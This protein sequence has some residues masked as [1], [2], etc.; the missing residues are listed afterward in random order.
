MIK[1]Y[2]STFTKPSD[3]YP[4]MRRFRDHLD[5]EKRSFADKTWDDWASRQR[6][7]PSLILLKQVLD[8]SSLEEAY[9]ILDEDAEQASLRHRNR[10]R[11]KAPKVPINSTAVSRD[12]NSEIPSSW[13]LGGREN[14][15]PHVLH[16]CEVREAAG[17][18]TT[19]KCLCGI[20]HRP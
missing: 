1:D 2:L 5:R 3:V 6:S 16:F 4:A 7:A 13:R 11:A 18:V 17:L 15:L 19:P 10:F 8:V 12:A 14:I 20:F 9:K